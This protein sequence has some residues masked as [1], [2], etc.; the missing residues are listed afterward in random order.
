MNEKL[1]VISVGG[2]KII[3]TKTGVIDNNFLAQLR[4]LLIQKTE[5]GHTFV[6][7]AGGGYTSRLYGDAAKKF[8]GVTGTKIPNENI[9]TVGIQ[10]CLTN[11]AYLREIVFKDIAGIEVCGADYYEPGSSSDRP[12]ILAAKKYKANT[13]IN[14]SNISHVYTADPEVDS[15]AKK[16]ENITWAEFRKIIPAEFSPNLSSPFDPTAARVAEEAN[17]EVVTLSDL[18][19]LEKYLNDET[20][21]GTRILPN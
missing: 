11:A 1:S 4:Q 7:I 15:D 21:E 14:L 16:I 18:G 12:A 3:P 5:D 10:A 8:S 19:E 17:I 9:D 2:S 6:L 13:A 20:F